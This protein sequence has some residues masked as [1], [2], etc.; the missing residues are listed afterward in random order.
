MNVHA[1]GANSVTFRIFCR[2]VLRP[3]QT[4]LAARWLPLTV[5][6]AIAAIAL[7]GQEARQASESALLKSTGVADS[8]DVRTIGIILSLIHI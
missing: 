4:R 5:I 6:L 3:C 1:N 2:N 8:E 7:Y